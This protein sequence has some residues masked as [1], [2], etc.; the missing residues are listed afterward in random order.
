MAMLQF[1][2]FANP[3]ACYG[4]S[5]PYFTPLFPQ[6]C[7]TPAPTAP[8]PAVEIS[9]PLCA[10]HGK[11]PTPS[12]VHYE[13]LDLKA[14]M[15]VVEHE[16]KR[17]KELLVKEGRYRDGAT[18]LIKKASGRKVTKPAKETA[19]KEGRAATVLDLSV[20]FQGTDIAANVID[21]VKE[22]M[23]RDDTVE[24]KLAAAGIPLWK[25]VA[26]PDKRYKV[27]YRLERDA[28]IV[29]RR[30]AFIHQ[31]R[32]GATQKC[33]QELRKLAGKRIIDSHMTLQNWAM[34]QPEIPA[35]KFVDPAY[36]S[37]VCVDVGDLLRNHILKNELTKQ[38]ICFS[39]PYNKDSYLVWYMVTTPLVQT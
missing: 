35:V 25:E 4:Y 8:A 18:G 1:A 11:A 31:A 29:G 12:N 22:A 26:I 36:S 2:Q 34:D 33:N 20:L 21:I 10:C 15:K 37:A 7:F 13:N 27:G 9:A 6:Q 24:E 19:I 16:N 28:A 32:T 38:F 17:L 39:F 23:K 30:N 14:R 5:Q 3:Q